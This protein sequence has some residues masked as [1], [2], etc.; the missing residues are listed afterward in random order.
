MVMIAACA[1]SGALAQPA[2]STAPPDSAMADSLAGRDARVIEIPRRLGPTPAPRSGSQAP[3]MP[4]SSRFDQPRWV[5]LRSLA[6]PGWGQLH[7]RAWLKALAVAGGEGALGLRML[8]DERA[9]GRLNRD[10]ESARR[11]LDEQ[12]EATAVTA[13]NDRLNQLTA[14]EWM[15]AGV[16]IYSLLDAYVDAHFRNFRIEFEHDPALPEGGAG[17]NAVRLNLEFR[18]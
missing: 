14:R 16:L 9:L 15:V 2:P 12:R 1:A 10:V 13:Y 11:A 6:F 4:R 18:W 8:D 17:V 7:N 3:A 5:M